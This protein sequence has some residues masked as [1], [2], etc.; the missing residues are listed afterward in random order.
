MEYLGYV[1]SPTVGGG[2]RA[3]NL[4]L[5]ISRYVLSPRLVEDIG[6]VT[7]LCGL[8]EYLGYVL[9]PRLV[10][11]IGCVTFLCG[12]VEYL[13]YVLSLHGWLRI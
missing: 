5:W 10:E 6:H 1:L 7:F 13:G 4:P 3:C 12:L 11:D 9:S 2:Y 8:V